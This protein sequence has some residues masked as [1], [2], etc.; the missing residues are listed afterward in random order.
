E[1]LQVKKHFLARC[2]QLPA[3][4]KPVRAVKAL[5]A[6][7]VMADAVAQHCHDLFGA[8]ARRN[9]EA[10]DQLASH[11]CSPA[12]SLMVPGLDHFAP[13]GKA[14]GPSRRRENW[15]RTRF[16]PRLIW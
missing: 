5:I 2:D 14:S 11:A 6:D 15:P 13:S 12:M 7:L 3:Q 9:V 16:Y 10:H 1:Q 4:R 8:R